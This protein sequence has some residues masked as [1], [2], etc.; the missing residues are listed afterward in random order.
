MTKANIEGGFR[1]A[2]L[3]PLDPESVIPKLDVQLR[4]STPVE[5]EASFPNPWV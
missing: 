3:V 1:G 4:T 2:V 5:E